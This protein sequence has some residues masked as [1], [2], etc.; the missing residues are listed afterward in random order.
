MFLSRT[1][2]GARARAKVLPA[3]GRAALGGT[4]ASADGP[5]IGPGPERTATP[6]P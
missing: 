3:F 6:G 5:P 2:I 1:C 4:A